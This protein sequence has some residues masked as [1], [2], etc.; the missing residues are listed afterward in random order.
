MESTDLNSLF[1][2]AGVGELFCQNCKN[3]MKLVSVEAADTGHSLRSYEC[4]PCD[5]RESYIV[6]V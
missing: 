2:P 3:A 1:V 6:D 5:I 4:T